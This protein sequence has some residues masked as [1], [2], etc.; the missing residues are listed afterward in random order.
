MFGE[1][2]GS[3]VIVV[4]VGG[5]ESGWFADALPNAVVLP[6]GAETVVGAWDGV[7]EMGVTLSP[8]SAVV[9]ESG[10]AVC[11]AVVLLLSAFFGRRG[12]S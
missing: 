9:F 11:S 2:G 12:S 3:V 8:L 5:G 1:R 6:S 7:G 4:V 10:F